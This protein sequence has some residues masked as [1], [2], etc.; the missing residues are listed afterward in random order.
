[1]IQTSSMHSL[2]FAGKYHSYRTNQFCRTKIGTENDSVNS[3][4]TSL[5]QK[6]TA[7]PGKNKQEQRRENKKVSF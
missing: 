2:C 4:V 1:M 7:G 6:N 5:G 3:M